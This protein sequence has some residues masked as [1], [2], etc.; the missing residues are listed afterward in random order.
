MD[1]SRNPQG[2]STDAAAAEVERLAR[3]NVK[4][5][6]A[7]AR[8]LAL[9][10]RCVCNEI[11]ANVT[12]AQREVRHGWPESESEDIAYSL[13]ELIVMFHH[14]LVMCPQEGK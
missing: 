13:P 10:I 2:S 1:A 9:A 11:I 8:A 4:N 14:Q 5:A 3:Q 12:D 6:P 7:R